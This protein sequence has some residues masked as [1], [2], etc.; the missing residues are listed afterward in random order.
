M[1]VAG[2]I[3]SR[4]NL[5]LIHAAPPVLGE[6]PEKARLIAFMAG[7]AV[8]DLI[9]RQHDGVVVAVDPDLANHL[10]VPR[11]LTLPPESIPGAREV[12]RA[13][14]CD[15]FLESLEIHVGEHQ[16]TLGR[17]VD[18]RDRNDPAVFVEID[19]C[20]CLRSHIGAPKGN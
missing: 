8:T 12:A 5:A 17:V 9:D 4:I 6:S 2:A 11:F 13:T 14:A 15:C 7:Y 19:R 3:L 1:S 16:K 20:R 10:E 18:G